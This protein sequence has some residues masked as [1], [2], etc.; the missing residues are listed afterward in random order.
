MADYYAKRTF[1]GYG[2]YDAQGMEIEI[3][4]GTSAKLAAKTKAAELN[5]GDIV[6]IE[7]DER[8]EYVRGSGREGRGAL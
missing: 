1:G 5:G 3:F 6:E 4:S 8:S 2:V 7:G